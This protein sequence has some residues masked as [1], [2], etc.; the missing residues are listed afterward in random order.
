VVAVE[1]G[2]YRALNEKEEK[3]FQYFM[4]GAGKGRTEKSKGF[5]LLC[6]LLA[7]FN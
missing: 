5:D 7:A 1:K 2:E 3:E 6:V 4:H